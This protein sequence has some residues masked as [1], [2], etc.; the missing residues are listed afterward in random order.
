[1]EQQ[2]DSQF[3]SSFCNL[4]S[5]KIEK[6]NYPVFERIMM[7]PHLITDLNTQRQP[8]ND[9]GINVSPLGKDKSSMVSI[10]EKT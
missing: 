9:E 1:M 8:L 7:P 2:N 3:L 5:S 6:E 4:S 10:I